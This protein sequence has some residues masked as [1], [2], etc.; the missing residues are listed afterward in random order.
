MTNENAAKSRLLESVILFPLERREQAVS[1]VLSG[2][3]RTRDIT[4]DPT[5]ATMRRKSHELD[6]RRETRL[7]QQLPLDGPT[8]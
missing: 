4:R 2:E 7:L 3:I 5:R 8:D 1:E 6:Q